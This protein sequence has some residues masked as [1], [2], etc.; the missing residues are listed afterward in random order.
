MK[1]QEL[2]CPQCGGKSEGEGL[3]NTCRVSQTRWVTIDPRVTSTY[4]PSCNAQKT[5]STWT[6]SERSREEIG[7]ELVR[8][9]VHLHKDVKSPKIDIAIR[10]RS[11]N[12]SYA[13][14]DVSGILY[15]IRVDQRAT[16]EIIWN[17]E[18]C[19]RCNRI[20]GSYYEGI[21]QVRA[22][23]RKILPGEVLAAR[24]IACE[25]EDQMQ[26]G[27]D[28][29]SYISEMEE[30]RE[31]LDITIGSQQIGLAISQA[32]VQRLGGRYSTHPKLVGEKAGKKLFRVT[33]S[34]R[35]PR[36]IRGDVLRIGRTYGQ[37]IQVDGH[38]I[39]YGDLTNGSVRTT[40]EDE[41][42]EL[43]GNIRDAADALVAYVDGDIIG[44]VDSGTGSACE[45][46]RGP[47][48]KVGP[49]EHIRVIRDRDTLIPVW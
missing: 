21:V 45:C 38:S 11:E 47:W 49:G 25:T 27:G 10:D 9:A 32:L 43:V 20:S 19:N 16:V 35:L 6:D 46:L 30:T 5:V 26:A 8:N 1:I 24:E 4:C 36:Y 29:L 2:I 37:V 15:G 13:D 42:D 18:Q 33:Y 31:G 40:R 44:L 14:V 28:R 41:I 7:P 17:K 12:R 23:G 3:C 48:Q 22:N 34:V 39:K